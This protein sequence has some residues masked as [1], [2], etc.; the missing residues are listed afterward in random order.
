MSSAP[1][2]A[3]VS[4][5]CVLGEGGR[6]VGSCR[7]VVKHLTLCIWA[8]SLPTGLGREMRVSERRR[9][10]LYL[11]PGGPRVRCASTF[12][13]PLQNALQGARNFGHPWAPARP[14]CA[15]AAR[16]LLNHHWDPSENTRTKAMSTWSAVTFNAFS[17]QFVNY[18]SDGALITCET[19]RGSPQY[20]VRR[21][22]THGAR[23][24]RR[25]RA[26]RRSRRCQSQSGEERPVGAHAYR[27]SARSTCARPTRARGGAGTA[28]LAACIAHRVHLR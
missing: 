6:D 9:S 24:R 12:L 4:E 10:M 16:P 1:R 22:Q 3:F 28:A 13:A 7:R 23:P 15:C 2:S 20:I 11:P 17:P 26:P 27:L 5:R 25:S 19:S 21:R 8:S 14:P 18:A